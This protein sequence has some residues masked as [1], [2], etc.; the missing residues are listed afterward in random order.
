VAEEV[1]KFLGDMHLESRKKNDPT[2][3][4]PAG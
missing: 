2:R 4:R 3:S 1:L